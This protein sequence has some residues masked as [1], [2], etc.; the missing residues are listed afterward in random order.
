MD[1]HCWYIQSN[2][3][4]SAIF[5]QEYLFKTF[6]EVSFFLCFLI[7]YSYYTYCT[8]THTHANHNHNIIIIRSTKINKANNLQSSICEQPIFVLCSALQDKGSQTLKHINKLRYFKMLVRYFFKEE[9]Y[10]LFFSKDSLN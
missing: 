2:M 4:L 10:I 9:K 3:L 8:H 5:K 7:A 6:M 1:V